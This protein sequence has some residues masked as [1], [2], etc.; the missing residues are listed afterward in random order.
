MI[1]FK[2]YSF[3]CPVLAD[4]AELGCTFASLVADW[5]A[6]LEDCCVFPLLDRFIVNPA[7]FIIVPLPSTPDFDP[8]LFAVQT[9]AAAPTN[10]PHKNETDFTQK[11]S[12]I[13]LKSIVVFA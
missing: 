4:D 8:F 11:T 13:V 7:N 9:T 12:L 2:L 1:C 6:L 5:P 10:A 3:E